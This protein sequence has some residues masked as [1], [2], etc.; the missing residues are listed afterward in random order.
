MS[1]EGIHLP[2]STIVNILT[3]GEKICT[4]LISQ[5]E[6]WNLCFVFSLRSIKRQ[7]NPKLV[8]RREGLKKTFKP[9]S[10]WVSLS[11]GCLSKL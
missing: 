7:K 3:R 8:E 2:P 9:Y 4:L 1:S 11:G 10:D 5:N 6:K